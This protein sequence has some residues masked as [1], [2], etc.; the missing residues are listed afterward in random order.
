VLPTMGAYLW[1]IIDMILVV[2]SI[3]SHR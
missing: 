2:L 1:T 3:H